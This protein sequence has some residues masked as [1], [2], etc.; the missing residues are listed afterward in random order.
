MT[1]QKMD[2]S[3]PP[4]CQILCVEKNFNDKSDTWWKF[5]LFE[6]YDINQA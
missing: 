2:D 6:V 3:Y 5:Q 4:T 1:I